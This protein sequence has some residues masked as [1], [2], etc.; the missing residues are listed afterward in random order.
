MPQLVKGGKWVFGWVIV[1]L[2]GEAKIPPTAFSEY[3]FQPGMQVIFLRGS[4]R[5][6]GFA[7]GKPEKLKQAKISL[8]PRLLGQAKIDSTGKVTLPAEIGIKPGERLLVARGSGLA[9]GFVQRGPIFEA[10]LEH[11]ELEVF[12]P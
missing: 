12:T 2:S 4:R 3:G 8:L 6:G 5:S 9:L 7:M 1:S 11:P 10:A